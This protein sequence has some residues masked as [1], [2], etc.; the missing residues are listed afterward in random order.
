[1]KDNRSALKRIHELEVMDFLLEQITTPW[2]ICYREVFKLVSDDTSMRLEILEK[3]GIK[4][5]A[6]KLHLQIIRQNYNSKILD[7]L[8]YLCAPGGK[9][10][11]RIQDNILDIMFGYE[12]IP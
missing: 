3:D 7:L 9:P 4:L 6:D 11:R 5:L 1:M 2:D 10:D 8:T 12:D